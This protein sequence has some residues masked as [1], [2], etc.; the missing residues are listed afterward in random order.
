[1]E[2]YLKIISKEEE[3]PLRTLKDLFL[4]GEMV[5]FKNLRGKPLG[6]GKNLNVKVNANLGTSP[7]I[8]DIEWERRKL[9]EA[10]KAGT[11]TIMD[12]STEGDLDRIRKMF[13]EESNV[14]VGTVPIY[15]AVVETVRKEG[16]LFKMKAKKIFEVIE[17]HAKDGVDFVTVHCGVNKKLLEEMRNNSR[18]MDMVSRGGAFHITWMVATGKENPLFE[19]YDDLLAIAKEYNLVLSLGDGFRPGA[20]EDANDKLQMEELLVV[21]ELV[22]KAREEGVQ[23]I[24]EGPGHV[25]L[26]EIE[27]NVLLE[28]KICKGAPYYVLGPLV[29]DIALGYDHISAAIGGAIAGKAGADFLCYVTPGEH[30]RLPTPEDVRE[31]VIAARIAA[32]AADIA[33]GKKSA[34]EWDR[35][36]S[37]FRKNRDWEKE[38]QSSLFPERAREIWEESKPLHPGVCTMCGEY[39]SLKLVE[40][41]LKKK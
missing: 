20:L 16:A 35:K 13:L 38:I 39:C 21:G 34:K 7:E 23:V 18:I 28:K 3:I 29:T 26:N 33:R 1:M 5:I 6:I 12:L 2:N 22:E 24:V 9:K 14:P 19:N 4:K 32:H 8:C 40:E 25:P 41:W 30:L 11:D 36:L 27:A 37:V 15:Q 17:R 10:I 31:G